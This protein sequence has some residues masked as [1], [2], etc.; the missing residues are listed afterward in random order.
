MGTFFLALVPYVESKPQRG[1][2]LPGVWPDLLGVGSSGIAPSAYRLHPC[3]SMW[4]LFG[5]TLFFQGGKLH[6]GLS[7]VCGFVDCVF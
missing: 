6:L 3:V 4:F 2:L 7:I 5:R 1:V